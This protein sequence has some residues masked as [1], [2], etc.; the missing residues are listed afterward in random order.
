M[1][2]AEFKYSDIKLNFQ[3]GLESCE[4]QLLDRDVCTSVSLFVHME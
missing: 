1:D 3:V 4:N 2:K